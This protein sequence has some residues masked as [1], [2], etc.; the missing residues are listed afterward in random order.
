M[1][2]ILETGGFQF[3]VKEGEKIKIPKLQVQPREKV[4]F[5]K[6]LFIGGEVPRIGAPY[7]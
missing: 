7:V 4:I 1:Y 5:D 3:S 6:V 2:A